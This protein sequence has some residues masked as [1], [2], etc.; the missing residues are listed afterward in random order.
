VEAGP[1]DL[2]V[3]D[4]SAERYTS[5]RIHPEGGAVAVGCVAGPC[6]GPGVEPVGVGRLAEKSLRFRGVPLH[7]VTVRGI[8]FPTVARWQA[9]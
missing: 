6:C 9:R 8:V 2:S 4:V 7:W 3:D 5:L 1:V